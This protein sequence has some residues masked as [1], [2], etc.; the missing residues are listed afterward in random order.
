[1]RGQIKAD[2]GDQQK[3]D[4][5]MRALRK[6]G[7]SVLAAFKLRRPQANKSKRGFLPALALGQLAF[8]EEGGKASV[9]IA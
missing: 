2:G 6:L 3:F 4:D 9:A 8:T 1:M 7:R 5:G